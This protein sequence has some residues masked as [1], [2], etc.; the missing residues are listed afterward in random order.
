MKKIL[1]I[2]TGGTISMKES[3]KGSIMETDH[4]PLSN[5][6]FNTALPTEEVH[7]F[8]IPSP[9]ITPDHML[10]LGKLIYD[11]IKTDQYY[12]IVVTHGT[13]TLEETAYF[14]DLYIDTSIPVIFTGAMRSSNEIGSDGLYNLLAAIRVA[15]APEAYD[16][17]VLVVMNDE[18]H[19]AQFVTKTSTSHVDTF[20]SPV[21][22]PV[23]LITDKDIH[24]LH[25]T[26]PKD[27]F[28]TSSLSKNVILMKVYTGMSGEVIDCLNES[29][30]DGMVLEAFGQGNVP[31]SIMPALIRHIQKGVL[32]LIVSRSPRGFVQPV[33]QYEGGG[34]ELLKEGIVFGNHLNGPKARLKLMLL[35]EK[36]LTKDEIKNSFSSL[37]SS[38]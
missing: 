24:F 9:H 30:L 4:H 38:S 2:H 37:N 27:T 23:G 33:Y 15:S 3:E 22:G 31:P 16:R 10:E 5:H 28:Y 35:L 18:I 17:G 7:L 25:E 26:G 34:H 14:I 1:I 8:H 12:G 19:D 20:K 32:V 29:H 11:K 6:H 13:D 21:S 36:N